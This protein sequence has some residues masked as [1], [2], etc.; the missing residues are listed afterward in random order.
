MFDYFTLK[1]IHVGC[2]VASI[3]GF[4]GRYL[5]M[6][7]ESPLRGARTLRVLPHVVDTVLLASAVAMVWQL[8]L[9]PLEHAWLAAKILAL[10]VYIVLGTIAL[11]RGRTRGVRAG[12]GAAAILV[13]AY[14]V[15]VAIS[16]SPLA[17]LAG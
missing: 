1:A 17:G 2:V 14:M 7:A 10:L 4:A 15:L 9:N 16:K 5:L 13:Y 6:L 3:A 12:A 11:R 8:S